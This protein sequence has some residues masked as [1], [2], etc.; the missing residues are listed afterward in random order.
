MGSHGEAL[1]KQLEEQNL[2]SISLV[3]GLSDSQWS[4]LCSSEGW[5]V[6]VTAHH[7]AGS[8]GPI[9]GMV[10]AIAT[11]GPLPPITPQLLD[12]M[13]AAHAQEFASVSREQTIDLLRQSAA[14]A[15]G[16]LRGLSD[17]QLQQ[18]ADLFGNT[19]SAEQVAQNFLLG[20]S[21][22]HFA[23]IQAALAAN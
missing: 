10:Q 6:G 17:E 22:E 21:R 23:S 20:H 19:V 11:R 12:Q 13:N 7:A 1:A 18:Q 9:S 14:Q 3:S 2:G 4:K 5:P 8:Y 15:T 16:V